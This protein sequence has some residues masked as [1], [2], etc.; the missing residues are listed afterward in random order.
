MPATAPRRASVS[1][2][3]YSPA[4]GSTS[5]AAVNNVN[6]TTRKIL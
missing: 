2:I 6:R 5:T 4:I 3:K 1:G